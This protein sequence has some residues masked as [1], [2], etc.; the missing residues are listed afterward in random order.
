MKKSIYIIFTLLSLVAFSSCEEE[1]FTTTFDKGELN[2]EVEEGYANLEISVSPPS[3]DIVSRGN[4]A[5]FPKDE[6]RW[7]TWEKFVDGSLLYHVTLFVIDSKNKLVAYRHFYNGSPDIKLEN[8]TE[9]SDPEGD[10]GFYENYSESNLWSGE[11][12]KTAATGVAVKATFK[13]SNPLH[14]NMEK[15][16]PGDYTIIAVANYSP[17]VDSGTNGR[18][19]S[20][21]GIT[22][23]YA[24]LGKESEDGDAEKVTTNGEEK[25]IPNNNGT[26]GDFTALV[27]A[28]TT[29]ITE[30]NNFAGV[31]N[32]LSNA[33]FS[34]QLNSGEDRVCKQ[35]PQPLVMIR[36]V[37]LNSGVVNQFTGELSRTFARVR[38]DVVNNDTQQFLG[39]RGFYFK[40][41]YASRRAYLFNDVNGGSINENYINFKLYE[42]TAD[43]IYVS[44]KD[45]LIPFTANTVDDIIQ[46]PTESSTPMFDCYI[47]EGKLAN[48]FAFKFTASYWADGNKGQA[49]KEVHIERFYDCEDRYDGFLDYNVFIRCETGTKTNANNESSSNI[50]MSSVVNTATKK[51]EVGIGYPEG[52]ASVKIKLGETYI[53][54]ESIWQIKLNK[55]ESDVEAGKVSLTYNDS[56][57]TGFETGTLRNFRTGMYL[58]TYDGGTDMTPKLSTIPDN[59][60]IFKLYLKDMYEIGTVFCY[61]DSEDD[62][63]GYYY[64]KYDATNGIKWVKFNGTLTANN[65]EYRYFTWE[66]IGG[67]SGT[68]TDVPIEKTING[69]AVSQTNTNEIARNDFFYGIVPIY[70]VT[71]NAHW[72]TIPAITV[73]TGLPTTDKTAVT[74]YYSDGKVMGT[75]TWGELKSENAK[76]LT[77]VETDTT[78]NTFGY[79]EYSENGTTYKTAVLTVAELSGSITFTA[80]TD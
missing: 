51:E 78:T 25:I 45:A 39:V 66:T 75:F 5:D 38:V 24:G 69:E 15:L 42:A 30:D 32:A 13:A 62:K 79:F 49:T 70:R 60:L 7:T 46:M 8:D 18:L 52:G 55:K 59:T 64:L 17:I 3:L 73:G 1:T 74:I 4:I 48:S 20:T 76:V 56:K 72:Y 29:G 43:S 26:G 28:V 50:L 44:S 23:T 11:I 36:K 16:Q 6:S 33:V 2:E 12:N 9:T 57:T 22:E 58:Q 27:N 35:V 14:G 37:T 10:N 65:G 63:K 34:Y 19:N 21:L 53:N 31:D 61:L 40:D 67:T 77:K 68:R 54:P 80:V 41:G 47:L 71:A